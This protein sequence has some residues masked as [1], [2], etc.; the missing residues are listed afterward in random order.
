MRTW[1]QRLLIS[2]IAVLAVACS[3]P[4]SM[5]YD[6]ALDPMTQLGGAKLQAQQSHK[7]ILIM[8][9]GDWCR[10]CHALHDFIHDNPNIDTSLDATF[11]RVKVY[12]GEDNLN[13]AFF[14]TLPAAP[15]VPHFWV[16]AADGTMLESVDTEQFETED[17]DYDAGKL[18]AFIERWQRRSAGVSAQSTAL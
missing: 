2:S 13:E 17:D 3:K 6:P 8:A 5:G 9:G 7:L 12:V 16:L 14:S 10:W 18:A 4:P 11:V 15:G 1:H